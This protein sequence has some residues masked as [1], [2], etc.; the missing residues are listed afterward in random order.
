MK[1]EMGLAVPLR[2][3]FAF[4]YRAEL[5]GALIEHEY[6]H[7]LIGESSDTPR[8][9]SCEVEDWRWVGLA[10]IQKE[11]DETPERFTVWFRLIFDRVR[12]HLNDE[13]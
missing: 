2:P 8:P 7:V 13:S 11:M 10:D 5:A 4:E 6:D 12:R 9:S 3:A 1:E